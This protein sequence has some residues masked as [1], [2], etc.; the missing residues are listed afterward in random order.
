MNEYIK[1]TIAWLQLFGVKRRIFPLRRRGDA[2]SLTLT[3][4]RAADGVR[5]AA[6]DD[7]T[8]AKEANDIVRRGLDKRCIAY[9]DYKRWRQKNPTI[10]TAVTD[11]EN[12]LIGFF[13]IFP[14]TDE[15]ARGLLDGEVHERSLGL[16]GILPYSGN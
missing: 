1:K 4:R 13:D 10:F 12:Q 7:E 8:I 14:L 3:L 6:R 11:S 2:E 15:A 16:S 9:E 5:F